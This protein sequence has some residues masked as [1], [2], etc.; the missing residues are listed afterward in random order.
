MLG[1]KFCGKGCDTLIVS[2]AKL[3]GSL[4]SSYGATRVPVISAAIFSR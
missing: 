4:A 3:A 2:Q 1:S